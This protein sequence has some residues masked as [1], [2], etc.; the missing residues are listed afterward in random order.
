MIQFPTA[1]R[2]TIKLAAAVLAAMPAVVIAQDS[3]SPSDLPQTASISPGQAQ[4]S[5]QWLAGQMVRH[6]PQTISGDDDW[7]NTKEVW[8]GVRVRRD[9]WKLKT[10]RRKKELRH[11]RWI[12]YQIE[13]PDVAS[14]RE[15]ATPQ[16]IDSVEI[17]SVTPDLRAWRIDAVA[18]APAD[19][20]VRMERWNL[21][22]QLYSI[23]IRGKMT[24]SMRTVLTLSIRPD[25]SE[26]LPAMQ[27]DA[28]VEQ[29]TLA[30][31]RFEVDRISKIGGD[32][33]E[34]IGDLAEHTIGKIW[35]R[36][37]NSRLVARLNRTIGENQADMRWSMIDW[38]HGLTLGTNFVRNE[39]IDGQRSP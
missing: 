38:I 34:E 36:K 31:E 35:I 20:S 27:L 37:E 21:G 16:P 28:N 15:S 29:A 9:G 5:F 24:V 4:E 6:I 18:R 10:N 2:W 14:G 23:E 17:Q 30:I 1:E 11:G 19:F 3:V 25:W 13:L 33:A 26:V 32:V 22:V 8:A 12:R 7:G 39:S